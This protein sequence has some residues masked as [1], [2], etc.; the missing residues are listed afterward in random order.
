M[1]SVAINDFRRQQFVLC[2]ST[3]KLTDLDDLSI[4]EPECQRN[5]DCSQE[6]LLK[7]LKLNRSYM[8][9][10]VVGCV[11]RACIGYNEKQNVINLYRHFV[12]L[13]LPINVPDVVRQDVKLLLSAYLTSNWSSKIVLKQAELLYK[14]IN[15]INLKNY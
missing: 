11:N 8:G 14:K 9:N 13:F 5:Q 3:L 15:D 1:G 2:G 12:S 7:D 10:E 4:E 6:E